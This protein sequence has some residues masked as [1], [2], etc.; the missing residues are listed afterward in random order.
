MENITATATLAES[1]R[2]RLLEAFGLRCYS[3]CQR[4]N[5]YAEAFFVVGA[6]P[7][8]HL[9]WKDMSGCTQFMKA[10]VMFRF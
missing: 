5:S 4:V 7:S 3:A 9:T 6:A 1:K 2:R 10:R 8:V